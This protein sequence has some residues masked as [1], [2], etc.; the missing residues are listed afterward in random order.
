MTRFKKAAAVIIAALITLFSAGCNDT[1]Q[2]AIIYFEIPERPSTLDPQTAST[3]SELSV[4]ANIYE[5]L[6]RKN[7]SGAIVCGICESFRLKA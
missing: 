2:D 1:Y 5:G 6:L 3:D 4:V 7:A